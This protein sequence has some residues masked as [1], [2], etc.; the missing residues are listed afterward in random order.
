MSPDDSGLARK[1]D[2][3]PHISA[4]PGW[5]ERG[6]TVTVTAKGINAP[7][8]ATVH[9][10]NLS[11]W[12][13]A[14]DVNAYDIDDIAE[15]EDALKEGLMQETNPLTGRHLADL[16]ALDRSL[17]DGGTAVLDF[18]TSSSRFHAGAQPATGNTAATSAKGTNILVVVD[19]GGN[20]TGYTRL[21]LQPTVELDLT[22]VRRTGRMEVTVSDWYYAT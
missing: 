4:K 15:L 8:D 6:D 11:N 22:E 3:T 18:D 20:V 14:F 7:G 21:G 16:P 10:L 19:A 5:V 2:I 1:Y 9:L 12:T 17:R 13:D